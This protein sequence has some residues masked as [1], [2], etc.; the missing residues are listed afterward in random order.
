MTVGVEPDDALIDAVHAKSEGNPFFVV[1]I[2]RLLSAEGRLET[3]PAEVAI[4]EEVRELIARRVGR[5]SGV[6]RDVLAI[7]AV[8]GRDFDV[9]VLQEVASLPGERLRETLR[10]AQAARV[11]APSG[12]G[13]F[14]FAHVLVSDTLAD[15]LS[16]SSRLQLH[17]GIGQALE[18]GVAGPLES[19]LAAIA[20]HLLEAAPAGEV[21]QG[22][23][24]ATAAAEQAEARF[25]HEEAARM[26]ERALS[27]LQLAPADERR[28]CDL[29]LALADA[30]HRAGDHADAR[31]IFRQAADIA[32]EIRSPARL[33]RAA[34]GF[35]G[36]RG[37]FGI[38]DHELL[39]L[40]RDA[41]AAPRVLHDR[42]R[43]R[44]LA[45]LAMELYFTGAEERRAILVDEALAIARRLGDPA[46]L[47]YTLNARYAALWGPENVEERLSIADEVIDLARRAGDHRLAREGRGR[48]I[49]ALLELGDIAAAHAAIEEHARA[50]NEL[51]QPFG[52]WQAA[53][54]RAAEALLAGRFEEGDSRAR[55]A[56]ELGCRMRMTDAE[57]CL[58]VQS[59]IAG[60]ELGR[61]AELQ[62]TVEQ[63]AARYPATRWT[64]GLAYLHTELGHRDEAGAAFEALA[65]PGFASLARDNQWLI[66]MTILADTCAFLGDRTRAAELRELLLPYAGRNVVIV[67]A[68]AC[69]GSADRALG[70]L[71]ATMGLWE[72]AVAHFEAALNLNAR[73]GARPWLARSEYGYAQM[74]LERGESGDAERAGT[75]LRRASRTAQELGMTTL[76][77]RVRALLA[78]TP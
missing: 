58:A 63:L 2:V 27:A 28:R 59:F 21:E 22:L 37:E 72:Q 53:I 12:P 26:Y 71:A 65:A 68:W 36:P 52:R 31:A 75:L 24:Y 43:A 30:Q 20:H 29:L 77:E 46:T 42:V 7:A 38:V 64:A 25:A 67:E 16:E 48:R 13:R 14:R 69:F 62:T 40:L 61:L 54:W 41:L 66:A 23:R 76:A 19:Q 15:S 11:I 8:I 9:R 44:L 47:A 3:A 10:E 18:R 1:E 34:L 57:S 45:R 17:L 78:A 4:P 5:L 33:A 32:R 73:L 6:C 60:M 51:R 56:F 55:E 35:G 49:V 74:L 50:A 70:L 39:S